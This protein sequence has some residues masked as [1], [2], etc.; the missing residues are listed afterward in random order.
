M[1]PALSPPLRGAIYVAVGHTRAALALHS[2]APFIGPE[3]LPTCV[4]R[5]EPTGSIAAAT[6]A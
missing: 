3:N 4:F 2:P 1:P 6:A 5:A